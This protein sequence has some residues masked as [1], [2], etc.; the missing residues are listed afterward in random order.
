MVQIVVCLLLGI[1]PLSQLPTNAETSPFG[2]L[3]TNLCE[4]LIKY[5]CI[6]ENAFENVSS[7]MVTISSRSYYVRH[8]ETKTPIIL[9]LTSPILR[10]ARVGC[11]PQWH[12]CLEWPR[13]GIDERTPHCPQGVDRALWDYSVCGCIRS[14]ANSNWLEP[15]IVLDNWLAPC[16]REDIIWINV[17]IIQWYINT[18][19]GG[20]C[21]LDCGDSSVSIVFVQSQYSICAKPSKL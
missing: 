12:K 7:K 6:Q 15:S 9:L 8:A 5:I 14:V 10:D 4:I 1:K 11:P 3:G 16:R 21:Y 20:R 13:N 18:E 17:H 19:L 2:Q